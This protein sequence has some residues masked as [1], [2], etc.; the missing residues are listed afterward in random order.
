MPNWV[1]NVAT[2]KYRNLDTGRTVSSTSLNK[3]RNDMAQAF[4]DRAAGLA[5]KLSAGD[6]T[7]ADFTKQMR[8]N[9]KDAT[10]AEYML[11]RGGRQMMKPPADRGRVGGLL[12][13]QYRHLDAFARAIVDD[14]LS[15]RQIANRAR[16]YAESSRG[17]FERG[18]AAAWNV[19]LPTYP[20]EQTCLSRCK[21]RWKIV[22][23]K[24]AGEVHATWVRNAGRESCDDCIGNEGRYA[25]LVIPLA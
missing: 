23:K 7:V 14:G 10:L 20:G 5:G 2:R 6:I 22:E 12:R 13:A 15:E 9:L 25:P 16:M 17:A 19:T 8:G 1:F 4:S 3:V 18:Q 11:G 21:C 24:A